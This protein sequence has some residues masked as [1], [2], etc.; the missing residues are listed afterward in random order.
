MLVTEYF[1]SSAFVGTAQDGITHLQG[2]ASGAQ[3]LIIPQISI[4][5]PTLPDLATQTL[6]SIEDWLAAI[7]YRGVDVSSSTTTTERLF[8]ASST[9]TGFDKLFRVGGTFYS[10]S[11]NFTFYTPSNLSDRPNLV[12]L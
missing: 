8:A 7:I 12:D 9:N 1:N 11:V 2:L 3:V 10:R 4:P 6:V 5:T